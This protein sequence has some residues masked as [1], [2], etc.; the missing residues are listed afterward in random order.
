MNQTKSVII[1]KKQTESVEFQKF[2]KWV[3]IAIPDYNSPIIVSRKYFDKEEARDSTYSWLLSI[4]PENF[5]SII[6]QKAKR[7]YLEGHY[8]RVYGDKSW[9]NKNILSLL[10]KNIK[11]RIFYLD[12]IYSSGFL[13]DGEKYLRRKIIFEFWTKDYEPK[14]YRYITKHPRVTDYWFRTKYSQRAQHAGLRLCIK[15]LPTKKEFK[16]LSK[17]IFNIKLNIWK[18]FNLKKYAQSNK[19]CKLAEGKINNNM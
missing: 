12:S 9:E 5:F 7:E 2:P 6:K 4:P 8:Q 18:T 19:W 17:D 3:Y 14:L 16:E 1:V 11:D 10:E 15:Y 13:Y